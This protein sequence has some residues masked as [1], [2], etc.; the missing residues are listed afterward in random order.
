MDAD[1]QEQA[2]FERSFAETA[3]IEIPAST[4]ASTDAA[5]EVVTE[6]AGAEAAAPEAS[7]APQGNATTEAEQQTQGTEPATAQAQEQD[8]DPV[9][10]EGFKRSEV[11]RLLGNAAEVET[12][13]RQLDKAH[14]HI[15]DLNRRVQQTQTAV[16]AAAP[17]TNGASPELQQK[18]QQFE[19]DY[20]EVA[21]YM[22]LMGVSPQSKPSG[23][24]PAD[25]QQPVAT[26][27][28]PAAQA[29]Y[30]PLTVEL[31]VMDRTHAGWREKIQSQ[32]FKLWLGAQGEEVQQAYDTAD[33][34]DGLSAVIGQYDQWATARQAASEKASKGQQR[35]Q[36]A[37][38]PSGNSPRPQAAPTE[39]EAMEAAFKRTLG[40]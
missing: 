27:E 25:A 10:F 32:D 7:D 36:K 26:G 33:T 29:G 13:K 3:G 35:L 8:D 11:R 12:L 14:G 6:P 9:V 15:G 18:L 31:A 1:Q 39:M 20:P 34:A 38:T 4:A 37:T 30:D 16:P 23:A 22:R 28:A 5:A 17:A 19:E 21:E 24:P 2:A 40:L